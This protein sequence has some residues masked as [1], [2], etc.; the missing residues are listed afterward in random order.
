MYTVNPCVGEGRKYVSIIRGA[1]EDVY[2][3]VFEVKISWTPLHIRVAGRPF[4]V[5]L[6]K[7]TLYHDQGSE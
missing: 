5:G 4:P 2:G 6:S 7:T 1:A 3:L